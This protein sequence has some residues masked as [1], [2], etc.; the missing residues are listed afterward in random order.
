MRHFTVYGVYRVYGCTPPLYTTVRTPCTCTPTHAHPVDPCV[1]MYM[2]MWH[3][4]PFII[5]RS[6]PSAII[7]ILVTIDNL[8]MA[9]GL[10]QSSGTANVSQWPPACQDCSVKAMLGLPTSST[11]AD[12]YFIKCDRTAIITKS[13]NKACPGS[14]TYPSYTSLHQ[15]TKP[16]KAGGLM[17]FPGNRCKRTRYSTHFNVKSVKR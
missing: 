11:R 17:R 7:N 6:R 5:F 14:I 12:E 3:E 8:G 2:A 16:T 4:V 10:S 9:E 13:T 15:C 1:C